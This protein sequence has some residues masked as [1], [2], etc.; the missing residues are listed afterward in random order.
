MRVEENANKLFNNES[1]SETNDNKNN[2]RFQQLNILLRSVIFLLG[3][4]ALPL[5][6]FSKRCFDSST[7]PLWS[8]SSHSTSVYP[9]RVY[10]GHIKAFLGPWTFLP[11]QR[12]WPLGERQFL[13]GH[14]AEHLSLSR[15]RSLTVPSCSQ[16][17][18]F[19]ECLSYFLPT[20]VFVKSAHTTKAAQG[21]RERTASS[22]AAGC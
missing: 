12:L 11:V 15:A 21:Y 8:Q 14:R 9:L 2:L 1:L 3:V 7:H 13:R 5:K 22:L 6:V 4:L 10:A 19:N 17:I 20:S 16:P 18:V